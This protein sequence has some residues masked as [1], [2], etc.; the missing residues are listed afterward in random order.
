MRH[1]RSYV[2][3]ACLWETS[4]RCGAGGIEGNRRRI[5]NFETLKF[6]VDLFGISLFGIY[7]EFGTILTCTEFVKILIY[8]ISIMNKLTF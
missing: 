7:L 8:T 1:V 2:R 4:V 6:W 5:G 3:H